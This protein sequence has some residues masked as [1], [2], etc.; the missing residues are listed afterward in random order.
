MTLRGLIYHWH[1]PV[2]NIND[3]W[4]FTQ[5]RW[6]VVLVEMTKWVCVGGM[7]EMVMSHFTV[8]IYYFICW[9]WFVDRFRLTSFN[10]NYPSLHQHVSDVITLCRGD[11]SCCGWTVYTPYHSFI[12]FMG[13][14]SSFLSC[15]LDVV[16]ITVDMSD[17][18]CCSF[19]HQRTERHRNCKN[20]VFHA[21]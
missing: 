13:V 15:T 12:L 3:Y 7:M 6:S 14:D 16:F 20:Y 10:I 2:Q 5:N 8:I 17:E 18:T 9:W 11:T 21:L 4:S 1:G 19:W